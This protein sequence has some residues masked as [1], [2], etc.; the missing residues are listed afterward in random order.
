MNKL[1]VAC[2]PLT[3][4]IYAGRIRKDGRTWCDGKQDVT[5][6]VIGAIIA[7]IGANKTIEVR[8]NGVVKFE[9]SVKEIKEIVPPKRRLTECGY[10]SFEE[11]DGELI[12]QCAKC[13]AIDAELKAQGN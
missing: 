13:K 12:E 5:S 6:D 8:E 10:C 4:N 1:R 2:S 9:I 11:A 3:G 7:K